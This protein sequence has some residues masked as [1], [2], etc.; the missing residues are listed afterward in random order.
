MV[1]LALK[2]SAAKRYF[3][4]VLTPA[5]WD[6]EKTMTDFTTM[7]RCDCCGFIKCA[8]SPLLMATTHARSPGILNTENRWLPRARIFCLI[9][10]QRQEGFWEPT[11]ST[12]F[13]VEARSMEEVANLPPLGRMAKMTTML[14]AAL[15]MLCDDG[16]NGLDGKREDDADEELLDGEN[17]GGEKGKRR[18]RDMLPVS[19]RVKRAATRAAAAGDLQDCPLTFSADALTASMPRRLA[20]LLQ[21]PAA[22]AETAAR[23][24]RHEARWAARVA[25]RT[26]P[27]GADKA[28]IAAALPVDTA[29]SPSPLKPR[30]LRSCS[31]R[32]FG[33]LPLAAP[34]QPAR[35]MSSRRSIRRD[36]V[37]A[38]EDEDAVEDAA[39]PGSCMVDGALAGFMQLATAVATPLRLGGGGRHAAL[40][41]CASSSEQ[42]PMATQSAGLGA[43]SGC[44]TVCGGVVVH[45]RPTSAEAKSAARRA[46]AER[47]AAERAA[48]EAEALAPEAAAAN[49][50]ACVEPA[51]EALQV[52]RVWTTLVVIASLEKL[53]FCWIWG[54]GNLYPEAEKTIVD[55]GREWVERYAAEHPRLA[56]ALRD[57]RVEEQARQLAGQWKRANEECMSKLRRSNGIRA[58]MGRS[59]V[60]RSFTG[61][62]RALVTKHDTLATFLAEPLD[63][64]QRWQSACVCLHR[65][66]LACANSQLARAVWMILITLVLETLLINIW[67]RAVAAP[68][69]ASAAGPGRMSMRGT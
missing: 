48:A 63:G 28:L 31:A 12:A 53:G 43:P 8:P 55:G 40:C 26:V 64:L 21:P 65:S 27:A 67:V 3:D 4:S 5:G 7:L 23:H 11:A 58:E 38:G 15:T 20:R 19:T 17:E 13:A 36:A 51:L 60:L 46:A 1:E 49:D 62:L 37:S 34:L 29:L 69:S 56:A 16:G 18:T 41:M 14:N 6:W 39:L 32:S 47:E 25:A 66:L 10:S 61:L 68:C 50:G 52:E 44:C 22:A 2:T 30:R 54:D 42:P 24:A 9:L 59:H 45:A 33:G 57:G 35:R